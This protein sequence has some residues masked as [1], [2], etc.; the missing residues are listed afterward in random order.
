MNARSSVK[1]GIVTA[2]GLLLS[3]SLALAQQKIS[4]GLAS[5]S[6]PGGA[7]RLVKQMGFFEKHGIDATVIPMEN[8]TIA[9]SGM[10]AGSL[11]FV[12]TAG[13]QIVV[14][15]SRNLD[16]VALRAVYS[17][18]A[19]VLVLSKAAAG[20]LPDT[21]K[22]SLNDRL[23][24][25]DGLLIASPGPTSSYTAVLAPA[26]QAGAKVRF[27]YMAQSAMVVALESGAI[28]GFVASAPFYAQ[29][30]VNGTGVV[31][32]SGV[33]G[34]FDYAPAAASVLSTTSA[35]AKA[36][37]D[38]VKRVIAAFEDFAK[39]LDERPADVKTAIA[40]IFPTLDAKLLDVLYTSEAQGFHGRP[41][42]IEDMKREIEFTK[43]S[44]VPLPNIDTLDPA[45]MIFQTKAN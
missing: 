27:T 36:N 22:A 18:F 1:L 26:K 5:A 9:V 3:S 16:I 20:K 45:A 14:S 15:R 30:T 24:A 44:G 10:L 11:Q 23:K 35:F 21:A 34:E 41:V 8:D 12:S 38:V 39:A 28:Q 6:L 13:N 7:A 33:K 43:A 40:A 2:I 29:P 32:I 17:N 25:L 42:T 19:G 31:W 4:I 37:P